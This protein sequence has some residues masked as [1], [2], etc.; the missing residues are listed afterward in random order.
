MC[1]RH[2]SRQYK[3]EGT[4]I[5][6]FAHQHAHAAI[7]DGSHA[8][9]RGIVAVDVNSGCDDGAKLIVLDEWL[10]LHNKKEITMNITGMSNGKR[11]RLLSAIQ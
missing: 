3:K 9:E 1:R 6:K 4:C 8:C 10:A 7:G 2:E 11:S 5:F